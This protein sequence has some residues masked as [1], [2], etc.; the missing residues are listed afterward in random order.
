MHQG[1]RFA[2]DSDGEDQN[3]SLKR[4]GSPD[5][6]IDVFADKDHNE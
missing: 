3:G 4:G 5:I 6:T 2:G 1:G